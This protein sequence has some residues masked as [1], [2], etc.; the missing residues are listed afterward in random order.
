MADKHPLI[1]F[2]LE[3]WLGLRNV[4][5]TTETGRRLTDEAT[6]E[7]FF[8]KA[9]ALFFMLPYER[10]DEISFVVIGFVRTS[11][12]AIKRCDVKGRDSAYRLPAHIYIVASVAVWEATSQARAALRPSSGTWDPE[13]L[14]PG[15]RL[16]PLLDKARA[17]PPSSDDKR[18]HCL[19]FSNNS[20]QWRNLWTS[21]PML[22]I[23]QR[24]WGHYGEL[25]VRSPVHGPLLGIREGDSTRSITCLGLPETKRSRFLTLIWRFLRRLDNRP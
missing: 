21:T 15:M 14:E 13:Q 11:E 8:L 1:G 3:G 2:R 10:R 12:G 23:C 16:Y 20:G 5:F 25:Q 9:N 6:T 7:T 19:H 4:V 18:A 22:S 17:S 24:R